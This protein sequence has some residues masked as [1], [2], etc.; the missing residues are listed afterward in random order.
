MVPL[1]RTNDKRVRPVLLLQVIS[2][3]P[4]QDEIFQDGMQETF[5]Q[6]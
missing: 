5:H 2:L 1:P 6:P 4:A 3:V